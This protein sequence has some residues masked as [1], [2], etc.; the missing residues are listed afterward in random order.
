MLNTAVVTSNQN[1]HPGLL[2]S[3]VEE[4]SSFA[5]EV[6]ETEVIEEEEEMDEEEEI[7]EETES[8]EDEK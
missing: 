1:I 7:E 8:E 5:E 3:M 6:E 2:Y 4:S